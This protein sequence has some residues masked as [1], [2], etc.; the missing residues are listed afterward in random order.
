[1]KPLPARLKIALLS[2]GI[3]GLVLV[4]FGGVTWML[5]HDLRIEALDREIRSLGSRHPGLF[6][7]RGNYERLG[8]MMEFTFGHD[9]TNRIIL[10]LTD[11]EGRTLFVS[12]HWPEDLT[13]A[14]LDSGLNELGH[15]A[16]SVEFETNDTAA[17]SPLEE[18]GMGRGGRGRGLG[19]GGGGPPPA[20]VFN[21]PPRFLT[22]CA[23]GA[24]WRMGVLGGDETSLI[25]GLNQKEVDHELNQLRGA[26]LLTLP[27]ALFLVGLGG[28]VVAGKALRPLKTIAD[29]AEQVTAQGLDQR[30]PEFGNSPEAN[31]VILVLNR[32]MD[33]LETSF[34]QAMRFSADASHEL[35]TPLAIMQ[36][37]L[38][39]AL[40]AAAPGS[41]EQQTFSDLLE[42]TQRLKTITRSLLLLAQADA[43]KLT[44]TREPVDL[45]LQ[46]E[47]IIE[48]ARVLAS[49]WRL[50]FE[51]QVQPHLRVQADRALLHTAL[52]NLITNAIKYNVPDGSVRVALARADQD[53][54][55]TVCNTGPGIPLEEQAR[56]F[57]RFHRV[58]RTG[59]GGRDG[60]GLGLSLARE[61][62][63]AHGGQLT[64]KESAAGLTCFE[65]SLPATS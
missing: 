36:G 28:W 35:K 54:L 46:L 57:D 37:E 25:V 19:P 60:I 32:M 62:V 5:I 49:A 34:R 17:P 58:H 40:H 56:V 9:Y 55:V 11:A 48:D 1:M 16:A 30:I 14:G 63:R 47:G 33:R 4:A 64:L 6:T 2:A 26:F 51:V 43:G 41:R 18:A 29:T 7:G 52:Y 65:L 15:V 31:R 50:T 23:G 22:A 21:K 8:A 38:E 59:G 27:V 10:L 53:I 61:I 3:S 42:E 45:S 13:F 44:L 24:R 39:N 12:P 20:V